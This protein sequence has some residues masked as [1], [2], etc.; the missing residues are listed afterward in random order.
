MTP[1]YVFALHSE[2]QLCALRSCSQLLVQSEEVNVLPAARLFKTISK[3]VAQVLFLQDS[4][5]AQT[6]TVEGSERRPPPSAWAGDKISRGRVSAPA[7]DVLINIWAA[8]L[9]H[10]VFPSPQLWEVV[11]MKSCLL[12]CRIS[13]AYFACLLSR[14]ALG[15]A[16][17]LVIPLPG[18]FAATL[19]LLPFCCLWVCLVGFFSFPS[20]FTDKFISLLTA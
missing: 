15:R 11:K 6:T 17:L 5:P 10:F 14:C 8:R 2:R 9:C 13:C 4:L 20:S 16:A 3:A 12:G 7:L 19:G 1:V 18:C